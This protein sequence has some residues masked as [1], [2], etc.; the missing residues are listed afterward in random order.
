MYKHANFGEEIRSLRVKKI[1][2][3]SQ[4]RFSWLAKTK[5]YDKR[6]TNKILQAI[7][8]SRIIPS[9]EDFLHWCCCRSVKEVYQHPYLFDNRKSLSK[10]T[11]QENLKN[12]KSIIQKAISDELYSRENA[13]CIIKSA[14]RHISHKF[15]FFNEYIILYYDFLIDDSFVKSILK[16]IYKQILWFLF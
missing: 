6:E 9:T 11:K 5:G 14:I 1:I 4:I 12:L 8:L 3:V 10:T 13:S 16:Y 15:Y 2:G 7:S